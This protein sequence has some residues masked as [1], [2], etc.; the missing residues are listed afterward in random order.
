MARTANELSAQLADQ[1]Q[2]ASQSIEHQLSLGC[3]ETKG[4]LLLLKTQVDEVAGTLQQ[5]THWQPQHQHQRG[6]RS[7]KSCLIGYDF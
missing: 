2:Q 7:E 4:E 5:P 3:S 1:L 6:T